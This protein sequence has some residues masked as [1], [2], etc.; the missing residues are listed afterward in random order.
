M[1]SSIIIEVDWPAMRKLNITKVS[2]DSL[3]FRSISNSR[4]SVTVYI[5]VLKSVV[6]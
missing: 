6:K 3:I 2:S 5:P 1:L 4:G